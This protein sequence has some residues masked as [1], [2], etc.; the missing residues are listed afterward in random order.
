MAAELGLAYRRLP[1]GRLPDPGLAFERESREAVPGRAEE[2]LD[3]GELG[4]SAHHPACHVSIL[5]RPR[6]VF[7]DDS[8]YHLQVG[9]ISA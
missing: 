5:R 9:S 2:L 4:L 6:R 8:A 1:E 7:R 3:R